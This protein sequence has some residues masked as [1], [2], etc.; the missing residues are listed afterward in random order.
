[1]FKMDFIMKRNVINLSFG[2]LSVF[3]F[4]SC[5]DDNEDT[6]V[7]YGVMQN[8]DSSNSY[9]ILTDRKSVV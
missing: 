1:M 9:E 2:I 6:Y 4:F 8:V 3:L 5:L 7:S